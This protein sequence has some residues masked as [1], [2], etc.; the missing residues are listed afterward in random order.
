MSVAWANSEGA[1][2]KN[3]AIHFGVLW[4]FLRHGAFSNKIQYL[5]TV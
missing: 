1:R 2:Y 5:V 3:N 4:R